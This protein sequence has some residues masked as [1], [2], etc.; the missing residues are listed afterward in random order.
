MAKVFPVSATGIQVSNMQKGSGRTAEACA[1][2]C[3]EM[4]DAHCFA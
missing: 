1:V 2:E 4:G 3:C